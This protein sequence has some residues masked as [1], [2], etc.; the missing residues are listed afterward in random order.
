MKKAKL[1]DVV[2]TMKN[3]LYKPAS[4]YGDDGIPCLRMYNIDAGRINCF[5][6]AF[7][8]LSCLSMLHGQA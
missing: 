2:E 8:H 7:V 4:E 1:G 5:I 3:G 6:I